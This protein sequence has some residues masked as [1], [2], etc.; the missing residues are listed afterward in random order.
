MLTMIHQMNDMDNMSSRNNVN[1]IDRL[2][3]G[4]LQRV[5]VPSLVKFEYQN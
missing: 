2:I 4:I 1:C 5:N 3:A